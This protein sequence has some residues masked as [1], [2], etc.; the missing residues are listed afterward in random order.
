MPLPKFDTVHCRTI[1]ERRRLNASV[2][3]LTNA[4]NVRAA[5]VTRAC[6]TLLERSVSYT[7][8]CVE[9]LRQDVNAISTLYDILDEATLKSSYQHLCYHLQTVA[10]ACLTVY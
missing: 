8:Q 10:H 7:T 2:C 4:G 6:I 5:C 1:A 9:M 3:I